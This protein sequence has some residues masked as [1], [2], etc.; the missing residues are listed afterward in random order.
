[1]IR[2]SLLKLACMGGWL[3]LV[4]DNFLHKNESRVSN[5]DLSVFHSRLN[6][7]LLSNDDD[8]EEDDAIY[9]MLEDFVLRNTWSKERALKSV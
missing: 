7:G 5:L 6:L 4:H 3:C 2:C 9:I 1:L 8:D